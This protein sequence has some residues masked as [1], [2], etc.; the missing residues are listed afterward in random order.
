MEYPPSCTVV[1]L[2]Q[3]PLWE[4]LINTS[5]ARGSSMST[6]ST[7][8]RGDRP[9]VNSAARIIVTLVTRRGLYVIAVGAD[10]IG[11]C[12][13]AQLRQ[14]SGGRAMSGMGGRY[15]ICAGAAAGQIAGNETVADP[16][17]VPDLGD[18]RYIYS[19]GRAVRPQYPCRLG[20]VCDDRRGGTGET[21]LICE[22]QFLML[23]AVQDHRGGAGDRNQFQERSRA[24]VLEVCLAWTADEEIESFPPSLAQQAV[25]GGCHWISHK[26]TSRQIDLRCVVED[27]G[28]NRIKV[29]S[30]APVGEQ[31]PPRSTNQGEDHPG[32]ALCVYDQFR[33]AARKVLGERSPQ[34]VI[35]DLS[36]KPRCSSL[37]G[38]ESSH[39]G[40]APAANPCGPHLVLEAAAGHAGQH[41][42]DVLQKISNANKHVA[43]LL[44]VVVAGRSRSRGGFSR[45]GVVVAGRSRN[46]GGFSRGGVVVAGRSRSLGGFSRGRGGSEGISEVV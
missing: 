2:W 3:I 24:E 25:Y 28:F 7:I 17:A 16:S 44:R 5:L 45:G 34:C 23:R 35:T 38:V 6:S 32:C 13:R 29:S 30:R 20:M 22:P 10:S 40:R 1:S 33:A 37:F 14:D 18:R 36:D 15:W 39:V 12:G 43:N 26:R 9:A 4:I 21:L 11:S 8:S 19:F 31:R 46:R 41:N 27:R 42:E